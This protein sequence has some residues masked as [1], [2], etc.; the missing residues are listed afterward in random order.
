[1]NRRFML[2]LG[3]AAFA[4][5]GT[6]ASTM[7]AQGRA[8]AASAANAKKAAEEAR[9]ARKA[10]EGRHGERAVR[11]A[12]AAVANDPRN[13]DYRATLG[14]AYLLAGRFTSAGQAL[15]DA[16]ALNPADGR[17]ALNLV[18]AQ[19]A[20]GNWAEAR[21]LLVAHAERIPASDRGLAYALAGDPVTAVQILSAA[22]REPGATP[23]TRQNLAL[24]LA[25]AG[26]WG[27]A[28]IVAA[29]DIA[30]DQLNARLLQWV[31]F[32][33][34]TNAYDQVAALLGV[35]AVEDPGQP[36]ALALA[37]QPAIAVAAAPTPASQPEEAYLAEPTVE[38][39]TV[40]LAQATPAP[41]PQ[42][43]PRLVFAPR[44][45]I[46]QPLPARNRTQPARIAQAIPVQATRATP[47]SFASGPYFVQLGAYANADVARDS[48]ANLVRR[49]AILQG[50][51]PQ[52]SSVSTPTGNFY[53]LSVGG[54]AR[55]GADSLCRTV[56][57]RGGRCFVRTQAGDAVARWYRA[58]G[59][60]VAAR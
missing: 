13:A 12:E 3:A 32:A 46:V 10:I 1:M 30:P 51:A 28:K 52:G 9:A 50:Q 47:A 26:R 44:R 5:C 53:R 2:S 21:T 41:S 31:A 37:Q 16:L 18:L 34:P 4:V 20:E 60:Q 57:S 36:V 19:I 6:G 40:E 43:T 55:Q 7:L 58:G 15:S 56:R 42:P 23:K 27:E 25:L 35:R 45:E 59:K 22:V 54:F 8:F 29:A 11:H 39:M 17:A 49:V 14:Q 33:R 48:W 24:S 38:P